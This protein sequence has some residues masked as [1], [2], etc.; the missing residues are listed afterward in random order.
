L[1]GTGAEE[2]RGFEALWKTLQGRVDEE[3]YQAVL[4]KLHQQA[5]DA[6]AWRDKCVFYFRSLQQPVAPEPTGSTPAATIAFN[7][8]SRR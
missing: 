2:V 7:Q 6:A 3:R 8:G 4:G 1:D 5:E